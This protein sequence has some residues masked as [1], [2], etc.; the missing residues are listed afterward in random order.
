M[1]RLGSWADHIIIQAVANANNLR[2]HIT[3]SAQNFTETTIVTSIYAEGN[4]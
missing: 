2:I 3:E 4:V 1:S